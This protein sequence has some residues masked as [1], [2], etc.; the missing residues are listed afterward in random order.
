MLSAFRDEVECKAT[1]DESLKA[2]KA[3]NEQPIDGIRHSRA[4]WVPSPFL[5]DNPN[6]LKSQVQG[7]YLYFYPR[8]RRIKCHTCC[9]EVDDYYQHHYQQQEPITSWVI[10]PDRPKP[11]RPRPPSSAAVAAATTPSPVNTWV[12]QFSTFPP[13]PYST[14][15][16]RRPWTT[17]RRP[18]TPAT[19][20]RRPWTTTRRPWANPTWLVTTRRPS[21]AA[22][23]NYPPISEIEI[24]EAKRNKDISNGSANS[25]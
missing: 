12:V 13:N 9:T 10:I 21:A 1:N 24:I 25:P 5:M 15:T 20:T 6:A 23:P 14:T 8:R 16:T 19:T 22:D 3:P 18:W 17:S 4:G 11:Q 7:D 2:A